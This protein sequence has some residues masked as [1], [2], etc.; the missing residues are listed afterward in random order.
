MDKG[1]IRK[2]MLKRRRSMSRE[3][4][5]DKSLQISE[6]VL[7]SPE[8]RAAKKIFVFISFDNEVDTGWII[9][10]ALADG[11][12]VAAPVVSGGRMHFR[13]FTL[14]DELESGQLGIKEPSMDFPK[15]Y[16]KKKDSLIIMPGTAFDRRRNRIGFGK[17]FYDRWLAERKGVKTIALAFDAQIYDGVI[18]A[19][20]HDIKPERIYTETEVIE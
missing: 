1:Q 6:K 18:P 12:K 4:V 9:R 3:A 11:K 8:Y 17:G 10:R 20:E 2:E 5:M 14:S 19:D 16:V 7:E 13:Y 15:A